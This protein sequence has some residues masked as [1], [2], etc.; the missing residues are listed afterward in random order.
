M[1]VSV[2][3]KVCEAWAEEDSA[4]SSE[5]STPEISEIF[6]HHFSEEDS[7]EVRVANEQISGMISRSG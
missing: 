4:D 2:Q 5:D 1:T 3:V 6:S 7:D